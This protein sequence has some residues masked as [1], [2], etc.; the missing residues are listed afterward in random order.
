MIEPIQPDGSKP[1]RP[2]VSNP[3][4]RPPTNEPTMPSTIVRQM[5]MS[6]LP[7]TI[8]RAMKPAI[9]PNRIHPRMVNSIAPSPSAFTLG[10][11]GARP[12]FPSAHGGRVGRRADP[13]DQV[14]RLGH[15]EALVAAVAGAGRGQVVQ[16][17]QLA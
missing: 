8:A 16:R 13:A 3:K 15:D 7:G 10:T 11:S 4:I 5:P 6:S 2:P 9:S 14:D 1:R 17:P 12:W